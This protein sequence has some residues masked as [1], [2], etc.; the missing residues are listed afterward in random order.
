MHAA[1]IETPLPP[2]PGAKPF[3]LKQLDFGVLSQCIHCGLCLPTCPTYDATKLEKHSPRGRI[4]L[5]RNVA[6]GRLDLTE[7]FGDEM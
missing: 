5:M 6:E 1:A 3:Y 2:S 7:A 4:H